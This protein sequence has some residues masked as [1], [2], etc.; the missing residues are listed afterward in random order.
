MRLKCFATD[1]DASLSF[2]ST[3]GR[4]SRS[5]S[6]SRLPISPVYNI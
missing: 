1:L 3:S 5:R 6:P 2:L 4:C